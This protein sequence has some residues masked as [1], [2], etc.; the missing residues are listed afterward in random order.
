MQCSTT[1]MYDVCCTYCLWAVFGDRRRSEFLWPTFGLLGGVTSTISPELPPGERLGLWLGKFVLQ[2]TEPDIEDDDWWWCC[3][4]WW[5]RSPELS[6]AKSKSS[7]SLAPSSS[8]LRAC[9]LFIPT[10]RIFHPYRWGETA[11]QHLKQTS[12]LS[13]P[14]ARFLHV[15]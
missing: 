10:T 7:L 3:R 8:K 4:W 12:L 6:A 9:C 2:T 1:A 15:Y 5:C 13:P 11:Q 14:N